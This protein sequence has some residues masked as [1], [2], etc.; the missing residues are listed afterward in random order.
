[1]RPHLLDLN[2]CDLQSQ[3]AWV[4]TILSEYY[5][6]ELKDKAAQELR[7]WISTLGSIY[8]EH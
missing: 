8:D 3:H 5:H 7:D 6:P 2:I 4:S 1:M